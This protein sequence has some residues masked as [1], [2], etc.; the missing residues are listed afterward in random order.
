MKS[1]IITLSGRDHMTQQDFNVLT[2]IN[3]IYLGLLGL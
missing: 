3:N 1:I 2:L